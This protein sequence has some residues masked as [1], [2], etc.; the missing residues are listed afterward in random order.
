[1]PSKRVHLRL[2][3]PSRQRTC[4]T[5]E[6]LY[7]RREGLAGAYC[8]TYLGMHESKYWPY[9]CWAVARSAVLSALLMTGAWLSLP[10]GPLCACLRLGRSL[11]SAASSLGRVVVVAKVLRALRETL[12]LALEA[13]TMAES[14]R[15][16]AYFEAMVGG[17]CG[18]LGVVVVLGYNNHSRRPR[19][20][21]RLQFNAVVIFNARP[22]LASRGRGCCRSRFL[23]VV[24][25]PPSFALRL[26]RWQHASC[27]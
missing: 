6:L 15:A 22:R 26:R 25:A 21:S 27:P 5:C 19:S 1:M 18:Y 8:W 20:C 2:T 7:P 13:R 10:C 12:V 24:A 17:M 11:T 3:H 9:L 4:E 16:M 23:S 14:G